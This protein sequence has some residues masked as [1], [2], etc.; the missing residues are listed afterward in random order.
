[1]SKATLANRCNSYFKYRFEDHRRKL[2]KFSLVSSGTTCR[3]TR[4]RVVSLKNFDKL[5]NAKYMEQERCF[6]SDGSPE[7]KVTSIFNSTLSN[8]S[9]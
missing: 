3:E 9:C 4:G 8:V 6:Q 2:Y 1:M 5:P 7:V